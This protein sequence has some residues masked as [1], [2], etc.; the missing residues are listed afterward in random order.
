MKKKTRFLR[1]APKHLLNTLSASEKTKIQRLK[2][3][4]TAIWAIE[5]LQSK[6]SKHY[7]RRE[8]R[9]ALDSYF[10]VNYIFNFRLIHY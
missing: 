8:F 4:S 9:K 6:A 1:A 7:K 2:G 3:I 10:E 5:N